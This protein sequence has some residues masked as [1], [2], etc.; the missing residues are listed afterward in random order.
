MKPIWATVD[1]ASDVFTAG[2]VNITSP[3]KIAVKPPIITKDSED[4]RRQQHNVGE[5]DQRSRPR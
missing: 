5:S 3:P 2:W 1:Q 4:A